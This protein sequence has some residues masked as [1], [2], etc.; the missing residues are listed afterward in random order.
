MQPIT[1]NRK[2]MGSSFS[3]LAYPDGGEQTPDKIAAAIGMAYAEISR[4]EDMLSDYRESPFNEINRHAGVRPVKVPSEVLALLKFSGEL[5]RA[6][7]GAFDPSY[8]AVGILWRE[9][10]KS[11]R[12]PDPVEIARA[13]THIGYNN[14]HMYMEQ[15]EVFLPHK[16][17]RLGLGSIGKSYG[18]DMAYSVLR[19]LGVKNFV[20]N[21]A[22]DLRVSSS[23]SSPRPWK[24]GIT[25][26]FR[27]D[28]APC[29]VVELSGGAVATSG[30]Y[31]RY[32]THSGKRHHHIIDA[33]TG[34]TRS[35]ISSVTVFAST[36]TVANAYTTAVMALGPVEGERF[37][38]AKKNARGLII[39]PEG[40]AV[41]CNMN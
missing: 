22:G 41:K 8:A 12:L 25:N 39:T 15:S 30:D 7:G 20:V 38:S 17:M 2:C 35:D 34:D 5:A 32:M 6:T 9:A 1:V 4:V 23:G 19:K 18:V 26:P 16:G 10:F 24:I 11:G 3:I 36:A 27:D 13:K 28:R 21:G 37:L 33:R 40:K 29:G 14:I 31:E